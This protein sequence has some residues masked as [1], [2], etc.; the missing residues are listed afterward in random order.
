MGWGLFGDGFVRI[1][2]SRLEVEL[3]NVSEMP[4]WRQR[5]PA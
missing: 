4:E 5:D 1:R 2:D 3:L